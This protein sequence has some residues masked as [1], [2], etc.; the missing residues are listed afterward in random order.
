LVRY[1]EPEELTKPTF[2]GLT[3][4]SKISAGNFLPKIVYVHRFDFI[5]LRVLVLLPSCAG[6][7]VTAR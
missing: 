2:V 4:S 6:Y 5:L 1:P 3:P 7:D